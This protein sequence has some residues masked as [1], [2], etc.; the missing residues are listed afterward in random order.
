MSGIL[1]Y[2]S[3]YSR[4]KEEPLRWKLIWLV[5]QETVRR[6]GCLEGDDKGESSKKIKEMRSNR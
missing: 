1:I 3:D 2:G 6:A 4:S 5:V